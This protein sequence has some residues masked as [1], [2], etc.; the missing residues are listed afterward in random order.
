M[1]AAVGE[2]VGIVFSFNVGTGDAGNV[3]FDVFSSSVGAGDGCTVSLNAMLPDS[4]V[5]FVT[6]SVVGEDDKVA[7]GDNVRV[8]DV[9]NSTGIVGDLVF[10][11]SSD[12]GTV[13]TNEVVGGNVELGELEGVSVVERMVGWLVDT[14]LIIGASVLVIGASVFTN[15]DG[16][17][18]TISFL[19]G[20]VGVFVVE[21]S[22]TSISSTSISSSSA[23]S[24]S[25]SSIMSSV[26]SS[27][28]F[29]YSPAF[30]CSQ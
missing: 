21:I 23:S 17:D 4:N 24:I 29:M 12:G 9:L 19:G 11:V 25:T 22:L 18:V 10:P 8:L 27:S 7:P 16:G 13:K 26:T 2:N 5:V 15:D 3:S 28:T 30:I 6:C 1:I 14:T 20:I